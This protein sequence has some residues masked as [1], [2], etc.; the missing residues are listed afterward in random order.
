VSATKLIIH[1]AGFALFLLTKGTKLP[2]L[3]T[4]HTGI[5]LVDLIYTLELQL[6]FFFSA[7]LSGFFALSFGFIAGWKLNFYVKGGCVYCFCVLDS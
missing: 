6:Y 5:D 7:F 4:E 2:K 1:L 3:L